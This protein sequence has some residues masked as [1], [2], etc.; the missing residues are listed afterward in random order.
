[1][2]WV[3]N[4]E[5]LASHHPA[6]ESENWRVIA[7]MLGLDEPIDT[8]SLGQVGISTSLEMPLVFLEVK[9]GHVLCADSWSSD[10][11]HS[12]L[13]EIAGMHGAMIR[14]EVALGHL[15]PAEQGS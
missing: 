3:R 14:D 8:T 12:R 6:A 11:D 15:M 7:E 2:T 4:V 1:M 10:F 9:T 5:P 13:I